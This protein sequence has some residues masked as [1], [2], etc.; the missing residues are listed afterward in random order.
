MMASVARRGAALADPLVVEVR[1]QYGNPLPDVP[2]TFTVTNGDGTIETMF[3]SFPSRTDTT[4]R[5][6]VLLTLGPYPGP[7][8]VEV[9]LGG[10]AITSF[11]A[12]GVVTDAIVPDHVLGTRRLPDGAIFRLGKGAHQ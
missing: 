5:A 4:G 9:S 2:V 3:S 7:N 6:R 12:E 1:D 8:A 11:H 10:G